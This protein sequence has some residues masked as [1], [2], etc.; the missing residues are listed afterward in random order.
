MVLAAAL[1]G[2]PARAATSMPSSSNVALIPSNIPVNSPGGLGVMPISSYVSGRS[3]D[4]FDKFSFKYVA[5]N[6]ITTATLSNFDTVALIQVHTSDLTSAAKAALAEFVANGGKLI[7]HDSDETSLNDYSWLLPGPYSTRIGAGCN[8]CGL[9]T[10]TSKIIENSG[11]ISA[12]PTDPTYVSLPELLK[13]TDAVGDANLLVSDDPRWFAAASGTNASNEAGAQVAYASNNGLIIYNGFDTDMIKPLASGPWLCIDAPNNACPP[14]AYPSV[15][16]LAQMWY[17]ELDKSWGPSSTPQGP[18]NGLPQTQ[19]VSSIGTPVPPATAG[20]P[21]N[22]R[23]VARQ[24]LFLRLKNLATHHRNVV[25]V[26]VYVNGRHVFRERG[27]RL[28]NVTLRRL[29][30]TGNVVVKIVATT[31]RRYHLIST[32]RYRACPKSA[33]M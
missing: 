30:Q 21:S 19:P 4:S 12:N 3:A 29:P 10:G 31:K 25:Q 13:Y 27:R 14:N 6:D 1:L 23:C 20:L 18:P 33:R 8:P 9:T 5:L 7:I 32:V 16:W 11:L 26:D 22:H 17:S 24:T 2:T 28:R 15:D